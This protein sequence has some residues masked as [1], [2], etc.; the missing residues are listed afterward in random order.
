MDEKSKKRPH[1]ILASLDAAFASVE[2]KPASKYTSKAALQANAAASQQAYQHKRKRRNKSSGT[3]QS[4][5][6]EKKGDDS[7]PNQAAVSKDKDRQEPVQSVAKYDPHYGRLDVEVLQVGLKNCSLVRLASMRKP[8]VLNAT[9]RQYIEALTTNQNTGAATDKLKNKV[10]QFDNPIRTTDAAKRAQNETQAQSAKLLSARQRRKLGLHLVSTPIK[11][12]EAQV[13]CE[14][15][16]RY[17]RD[18]LQDDFGQV[19]DEAV[20]SA[21]IQAKLKT[22][23]LSG[24]PIEVVKSRNP[25]NIGIEGIIISEKAHIVQV[26]VRE[27]GKVISLAV[28]TYALL[29]TDIL[30]SGPTLNSLAFPRIEPNVFA[31]EGPEVLPTRVVSR[32][33]DRTAALQAAPVYSS[34]TDPDG[35]KI[36]EFKYA[37]S[38][39]GMRSIHALRPEDMS[40][41]SCLTNTEYD[42]E[43]NLSH[44]SP[45]TVYHMLN[46]LVETVRANSVNTS[47][48]KTDFKDVLDSAPQPGDLTTKTVAE[49]LRTFLATFP[50][51]VRFVARAKTRW[52]SGAGNFLSHYLLDHK[53]WMGVWATHFDD[54]DN[55]KPGIQICIDDLDR[56]LLCEKTW[57]DFGRLKPQGTVDKLWDDITSRAVALQKANP[58]L[59]L[60]MTIIEAESDPLTLLGGAVVIAHK[61]FN[62][63]VL[64]RQQ[65]C[66][67]GTKDCELQTIQE[68]RYEGRVLYTDV[69]EWNYITGLLRYGAQAYMIARLVCLLVGCYRIAPRA[70]GSGAQRGVKRLQTAF[71]LFFAMPCQVVVYGSFIPVLAYALAHIVDGVVLY[72]IDDGSLSS[73]SHFFACSFAEMI[74]LLAVRTRNVWFAAFIVRV[75]VFINTSGN[76]T[77]AMGVTAFKGYLLP[78]LSTAAIAFVITNPSFRDARVLEANEVEP[79]PTFMLIRA[80]TLDSWKMNA[81]GVYTDIIMLGLACFCYLGA[82][83]LFHVIRRLVRGKSSN[84]E[85]P[86]VLSWWPTSLCWTDCD[87]PYSAGYLWDPSCLV[88]GWENDM[89]ATMLGSEPPPVRRECRISEGIL[90]KTTTKYVLSEIPTRVAL[91]NVLFLSDPWN[92]MTLRLGFSHIHLYH[93]EQD[94]VVRYVLHPYSRPR[95]L[96]EFEFKPEEVLLEKTLNAAEVDWDHLVLCR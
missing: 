26:C 49:L 66:S 56:P 91:M 27:S 13:L 14:I 19:K 25:C 42:E 33:F 67:P 64:Y 94:G 46:D 3:Q 88:V 38:S 7:K 39:Y 15:W 4:N 36:S 11:Y 47:C 59:T 10:M 83:I 41:P 44:L 55:T 24:C 29:V 78:Y 17:A 70:V 68:V 86:N 53:Y 93:L 22:L 74:R 69:I 96:R 12:S 21:R 72:H 34:S 85:E 76:W 92:Y 16:R 54:F 5:G 48:Y 50:Q 89:F 84:G 31:T 32:S 61:I 1:D 65:L 82:R 23:D 2:S 51:R 87:V 6:N 62:V 81:G 60:D 35:T 73:P 79:S 52:I 90:L 28:F 95:F 57:A 40:W 30:R 63:V 20:R 45:E 18:I 58:T 77:P 71:R 9:L 37:P 8:N 80:E 43:C 75:I